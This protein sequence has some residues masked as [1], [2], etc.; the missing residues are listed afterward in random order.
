MNLLTIVNF[1]QTSGLDYDI[2][3]G[4]GKL[5]CF[6]TNRIGHVSLFFPPNI[7]N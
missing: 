5:Y 4:N 3:H 2:N 7:L 6:H 1:K